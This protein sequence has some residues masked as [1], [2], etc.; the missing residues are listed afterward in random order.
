[1]KHAV[2]GAGGVGGLI[3]GALARAGHEVVLL[4]RS[5]GLAEHPDHLR[6]E[7]ALLGSFN[8]PVQLAARLEGPVDYLWVTVK[9][10][11][12]EQALQA[13][14]GRALGEG[15]VVT[16]MNGVDH[17]GRLREVYGSR[18]VIAGTIRVESERVAPGRILHQS[19]FALVELSRDDGLREQLEEAGISC[20][21]VD[22]E[23]TMLWSKLVMLAPMA[24]ATSA[25]GSP[26]GKVRR[27]VAARRRLEA[28]A[29][30][31][32]AVSAAIGAHVEPDGVMRT[33][34]ELMPAGMRSSMQKDLAAGRP[35]ELDAIAGPILRGGKKHGIAVP[36]TEELAGLVADQARR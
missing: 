13:A 24:L 28:T 6:I 4:L 15:R 36:A 9:S 25:H 32:L 11:Q 16:L 7:S 21:L 10:P 12:L 1:V 30:E 3:G 27:D 26:I 8:A 35:L 14:P 2:L 5:E 34:L 18:R 29:R 33:L 23:T 19:P 31:A 17:V 20:T 22:D